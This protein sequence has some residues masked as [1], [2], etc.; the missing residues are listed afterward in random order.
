MKKKRS[1][2]R[3]M[4]ET[5]MQGEL[6]FQ[7]VEKDEKKESLKS[8]ERESGFSGRL[9]EWKRRCCFSEGNNTNSAESI[10]MIKAVISK[11]AVVILNGSK[12][13]KYFQENH[14]RWA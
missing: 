14:Q 9:Y 6:R 11:W 8:S 13:R 12:R 7:F 3:Q 5:Q 10:E 4:N 1:I 2:F